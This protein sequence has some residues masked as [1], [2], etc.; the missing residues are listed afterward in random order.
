MQ[1]QTFIRLFI[2]EFNSKANKFIVGD[3]EKLKANSL[4]LSRDS[5]KSR[6]LNPLCV[7]FFISL[8]Q[9]W[10][11]S[12][13]SSSIQNFRAFTATPTS[14]SCSQLGWVLC[15]LQTLKHKAKDYASRSN[16]KI[17]LFLEFSSYIYV[18]FA[19]VAAGKTAMRPAIAEGILL[20]Q[21]MNQVLE[22]FREYLV[23]VLLGRRWSLSIWFQINR[24]KF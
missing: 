23:R 3:L 2:F 22:K 12:R 17:R 1:I 14:A 16:Q 13:I 24:G 8:S 10:I 11:T 4:I 9:K 7:E 5:W 20:A 18:C 19:R 15:S 6:S 21:K